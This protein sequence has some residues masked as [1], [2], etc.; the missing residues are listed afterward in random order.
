MELA[1]NEPSCHVRLT[2]Y[3]KGIAERLASEKWQ[4]HISRILHKNAMCGN[5]TPHAG[6]KESSIVINLVTSLTLA[7]SDILYTLQIAARF[8][9]IPLWTLP[10]VGNLKDDTRLFDFLVFCVGRLSISPLQNIE[11]LFVCGQTFM[12]RI[13]SGASFSLEKKIALW[14]SVRLRK[15]KQIFKF[16]LFYRA[17]TSRKYFT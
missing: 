15:K 10:C 13:W 3:R 1:G 17:Q 11:I 16:I 12:Q 4:K 7:R 2:R 14:K 6:G 5:V 8:I 9:I